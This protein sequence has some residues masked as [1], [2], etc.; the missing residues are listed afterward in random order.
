MFQQVYCMTCT[1]FMLVFVEMFFCTSLSCSFV[2]LLHVV[3]V[4]HLC[5]TC[6]LLIYFTIFPYVVVW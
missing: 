5:S 6:V 1:D 2:L 4:L 3:V